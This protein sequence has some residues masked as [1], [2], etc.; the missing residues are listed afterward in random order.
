LI[1]ITIKRF[2]GEINEFEKEQKDHDSFSGPTSSTGF[3]RNPPKGYGK[4]E[5]S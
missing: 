1:L 2:L 4:L 5:E 3:V